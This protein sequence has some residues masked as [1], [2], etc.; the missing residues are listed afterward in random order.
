MSRCFPFPP[1]G[2]EKKPITDEIDLLKKEKRKEKKHK[3]DKK[4]KDKKDKKE[5]EK[6]R[7][8]GRH[9]DKKDKHRDKKKDKE[10]SRTNTPD[11]KSY[12]Q[13]EGYNGEKVHHNG[14]QIKEKSNSTDVKRLSIPYPDQNGDLVR[15]RFKVEDVE[16]SKLVQELRRRI[17]DEESGMGS[18]QSVV[19]GRKNSFNRTDIE[20]MDGRQ[21]VMD[22][23]QPVMDV[24]GFGRNVV[25]PDRINGATPPPFD[26]KIDRRVEQR[27]K[28][29]EKGNDD[30]RGDKRKNKDRDK[31]GKEKSMEKEKK[32]EK[33]KEKSEQ[34]KIERDKKKHFKNS[35][36]VASPNNLSTHLLDNRLQGASN[37]GNL[38]KRKDMETN[39]VLHENVLRPNKMARPISN[40]P[41]ENGR[42]L[43]FLQN[44]GSSVLLD[45]QGASQ[46]L[47]L[48]SFN[49]GS[50]DGL[51]GQR[52][53]DMIASQPGS[54]SAKKPPVSA[55]NHITSKPAPIHS[56]PVITNHVAF[57]S[58]PARA[59]KTQP[60]HIVV[61][62]SPIRATKPQPYHV[63]A[64]SSPHSTKSQ[65]YHI[66]AQSSP[67]HSTKSQS[68]HIAAQS[69]PARSTKSQSNHIAAQSSPARS[70][71]SQSNHIAAQSSPARSTKSQP[72]HI[73]VQSSPA[74]ST[75]SQPNHIAAQ[76]SPS[77]STKSQSNYI[78]AQL[79]TSKP[80]P[81][82]PN[83]IANHHLLPPLSSPPPPTTTAKQPIFQS[84]PPPSVVNN[85]AVPPP[86]P[87]PQK[88]PP[89]PDTKYLNQVLS[90]PK[91]DPWCA[92][93]DQE[94][95]Y[96][97][98]TGRPVSEKPTTEELQVQVWSEAKH[99]ESVDVCALPY[100]IPY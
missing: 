40:I 98:K 16:N 39:G 50:K 56:P 30:K 89:H 66:A 64:Q 9:K 97:S 78:V 61:Q 31:H 92:F 27:E 1:P 34:K 29:Q 68:N 47:S 36:A 52:V 83:P 21:P 42:K 95:L 73:A 7:S 90:V 43:D 35:E 99:I 15:N 75:K 19:D 93:D 82:I 70:T 17:R 28:M 23:R 96:N 88:K 58:S 77:R 41:P 2:Y 79:P 44:P 11:N 5:R 32:E 45:K 33:L 3:K 13:F 46:G 67:V 63:A 18:H 69:S 91:L 8:E 62:S 100:V 84:K 12:G 65:S 86:M 10:K 54:V 80:L 26:K 85:L 60:N 87:I 38:R 20:K 59:T 49:V 48:S 55:F 14:E 6:D 94:W 74:R 76:S 51:G 25:V 37:E 4:E 72:N 81:S 71:K 57:Q 53:N 24:A 22:S